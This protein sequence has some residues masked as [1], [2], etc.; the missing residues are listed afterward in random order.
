MP[1]LFD[2]LGEFAKSAAD[3]TNEFIEQNKLN[4]RISAEEANISK[5]KE[6]IGNYFF[7]KY[8]SGQLPEGPTAEWFDGIKSAQVK[9]IELQAELDAMKAEQEPKTESTPTQ[10]GQEV[11]TTAS[12]ICQTCGAENKLGSKFCATCG[13]KL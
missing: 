12:L 8:E 13:A 7:A 2:K 5:L 4:S 9:I 6:Q 10:E 1:N 11:N 3:K